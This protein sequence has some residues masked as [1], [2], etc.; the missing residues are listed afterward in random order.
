MLL[1]N[2]REIVSFSVCISCPDELKIILTK[3]DIL[4]VMSKQ[5]CSN[6]GIMNTRASIKLLFTCLRL[7]IQAC[8][9][10]FRFGFV[11]YHIYR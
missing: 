4:T 3:L 9:N 6:N 10:I 8:Q 5:V 11:Y 2:N 7:S 1:H